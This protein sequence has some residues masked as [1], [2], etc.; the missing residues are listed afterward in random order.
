MAITKASVVTGLSHVKDKTPVQFK[1]FGLFFIKLM[2]LKVADQEFI[3]DGLKNAASKVSGNHMI[4]I[5]SFSR[6]KIKLKENEQQFRFLIE[7]EFRCCLCGGMD[8]REVNICNGSFG[9]VC[10]VCYDKSEEYRM[11][12]ANEAKYD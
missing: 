11:D 3:V 2:M 4:K 6:P 5:I 1:S 8:S 9:E 10:E 7:H 12:A